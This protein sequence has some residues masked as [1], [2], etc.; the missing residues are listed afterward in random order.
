MMEPPYSCC[1]V[2]YRYHAECMALDTHDGSI[3]SSTAQKLKAYYG[4]KDPSKVKIICGATFIS[5]KVIM[6]LT[7]L[8]FIVLF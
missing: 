6:I 4:W 5:K 1:F 7:A 2:R 3:Y 8:S